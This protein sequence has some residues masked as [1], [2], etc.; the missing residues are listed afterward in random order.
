[1]YMQRIDTATD[2]GSCYTLRARPMKL[3]VLA[4]M[5]QLQRCHLFTGQI[6][7]G[8]VNAFC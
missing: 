1:M 7:I 5:L 6:F 3:F 8:A 4:S 2:G